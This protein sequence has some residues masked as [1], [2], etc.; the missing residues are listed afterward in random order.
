MMSVL[1]D[2]LPVGREVDLAE[3]EVF[4]LL[5]NRRRRFVLHA[6]RHRGS[7]AEIGWLAERVAAWENGVTVE[8]LA[9][10]ERKSAYTALQQ[11]HLPKMDDVGVVEFDERGG[12]VRATE[13]AEELDVY[14]E[15][16]QGDEIP[17][18]GY[19]LGLA[20][21]G[22]SLLLAL[23]VDAVPFSLLPDLAWI[24]FLV[25]ALLASALAHGYAARR[26]RIGADEIPPE[27]ER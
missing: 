6:L 27:V 25:A 20:A 16:V 2:G 4:S 21:L 26:R 24:A 17:W 23:W 18:Y 19:Y 1:D 10:N 15:V 22:A 7:P 3:D 14:L 5:A 12:T 9:A 8:E 13:A 11:T